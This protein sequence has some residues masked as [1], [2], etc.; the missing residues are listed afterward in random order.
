MRSAVAVLVSLTV[1]TSPARAWASASADG[2]VDPD[3]SA[4]APP[5]EEPLSGSWA[6]A[7][8]GLVPGLLLSG[9]GHFVMGDRPS[10][11]RLLAMQGVGMLGMIGGVGVLGLVGGSEKLAPI[12]VPLAVSGVGIFG[13]STLVDIV[14]AA[15]GHHPWPEPHRP[16]GLAVRAGYVGLYASR[17]TFGQLGGVGIDWQGERLS[18]GAGGLLHPRLDYFEYGGSVGWLL[19]TRQGDPVTRLT[20]MAALSHQGF[21]SQGTAMST[22]RGLGELRW[23]L[24]MW[25]PTMQNAWVLGRLG[26]G[27]DLLHFEQ[28]PGFEDGLPFIV[29]DIGLGLR[30]TERVELELAYRQRKGELPGGM[31]L[32]AGLA[33]F[34]GMMELNGRVTLSRRWALVPGVRLGNG[35]MPW[36]MVESQGY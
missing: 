3:G 1:L 26:W 12:Y 29:A 7:A 9:S 18:L 4:Q 16:S 34:V 35:V 14:G 11:Y 13:L 10:A 30:V 5:M 24:G 20:L 15:R 27:F 36:L 8:A 6:G 28:A 23:N 31:N 2:P 32:S 25:L 21:A 22:G 19:W 17:H 33:G